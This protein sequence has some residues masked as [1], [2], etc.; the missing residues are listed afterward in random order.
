MSVIT[1]PSF[2]LRC[3]FPDCGRDTGDFGEYGAYGSLADA[4]DD[5]EDMDGYHGDLGTSCPDHTTWREMPGEPGIEERA[6]MPH[7]ID[8]MFVVAERYIAERI[9]SAT[10]HALMRHGDR[11]RDAAHCAAR[12]HGRAL[13]HSLAG[14][15]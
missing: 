1:P 10:R 7:T 9:E 8:S 11:V 15:A 14:W 4:I 3:D 6:P 5:W 13:Y 2:A 12:R